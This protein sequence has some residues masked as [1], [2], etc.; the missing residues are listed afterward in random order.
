MTIIEYSKHKVC[1]QSELVA[2]EIV[3]TPHHGWR[4][5]VAKINIAMKL[6]EYSK[7]C[8]GCATMGSGFVISSYTV[9][10]PDV[11]YLS[12]QIA[13]N[14][15]SV[16]DWFQV[17]PTIAIEIK[18]FDEHQDL[19]T[20]ANYYFDKGTCEVWIVEPDSQTIT[21]RTQTSIRVLD[22]SQTLETEVLPDFQMPLTEVFEDPN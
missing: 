2:G 14:S 19:D 9:L 3:E 4:H 20:K 18:D 15:L 22:K 21:I 6:R 1:A 10:G 5:G 16:N 8:G 17:A 7:C 13:K 11:T 12:S